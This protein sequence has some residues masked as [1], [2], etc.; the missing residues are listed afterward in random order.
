MFRLAMIVLA[1]ISFCGSV[2][3]AESVPPATLS[4][5]FFDSTPIATTDARGRTSHL[6]F[7][8][9]GSLKRIN[10]AGRESEGVWRL[11]DEGFCMQVGTAKRESCYIVLKREDGKFSAL[12]QSGKP[13]VWEK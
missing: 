9:D 6:I 7:A 4:A 1:V 2:V 12:K 8:P 11:S 13:F 10:A 5:A 3:A